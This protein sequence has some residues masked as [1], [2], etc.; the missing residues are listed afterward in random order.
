M[1]AHLTSLS[2]KNRFT[3]QSPVSASY[4]YFFGVPWHRSSDDLPHSITLFY[5]GCPLPIFEEQGLL[6]QQPKAKT[7]KCNVLSPELKILDRQDTR[8]PKEA[9]RQTLM[10]THESGSQDPTKCLCDRKKQALGGKDEHLIQ[11]MTTALKGR[12]K[13]TYIRSSPCKNLTLRFFFRQTPTDFIFS[14][15]FTI[16]PKY[17]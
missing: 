12:I 17:S 11:S 6:L 7:D 2:S 3:I 5:R 4:M 16:C 14:A 8:H 13:F 10:V 15:N 1:I 9:S